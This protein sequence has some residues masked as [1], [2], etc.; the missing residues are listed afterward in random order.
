MRIK[1][2]A[3]YGVIGLGRFGLALARTLAEA[4]KDVLVIDNNEAKIRDVRRYTESAF[5][6][7]DLSKETLE[8]AG[9]HNCDTVIVCIGEKIDV[10]IL[11][12]LN[13]VSLGV[14]NV[15]AKAISY[16]QGKVLEKIG[17][18]VVYPEHDSAVR[19]AKKLVSRS[20]L[21]YIPLGYDIQIAELKVTKY[22][23]GM[24]VM[25]LNLRQKFG[26]NIIAIERE[27]IITTEIKPEFV[28]NE[29]DTIVAIGKEDNII[30]AEEYLSK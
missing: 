12:T 1:K 18:N 22:Y 15:I 14:P 10:S 19:L 5:V 17:A 27:G 28:F 3:S 29:N 23:A 9:I 4:G 25:K 8:E 24:D 6:A 7:K 30:K 16:E 20:V 13:V 2:T 21:E 11:T 26:L